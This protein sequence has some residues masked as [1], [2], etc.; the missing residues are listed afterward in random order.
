MIICEKEQCTGCFACVNICPQKCITMTEM[1]FGCIHPKVDDDA[2]INCGLCIKVCPNNNKIPKHAARHVYAS[3]SKDDTDRVASTSGGAAT[4]FS[5]KMIQDGGVVFGAAIDEHCNIVHK[6][7]DTIESCEGFRGSKYVQSH[8]EYSYTNAKKKL[9]EDIPVLFIGTPCQIAGLL[10]YLQKP[11][12]NLITCDLICH[13]TPPQKLLREHMK[14]VLKKEN[15]GG[16]RFTFRSTLGFGMS[17]K[18]YEKNKKI[19]DKPF[20]NDLYYLGF[21]KALFCRDSCYQC[22]YASKERISDITIGDFWGLGKEEAFDYDVKRGVSLIIPN[23]DKGQAFVNSCEDKLELFER[24]I[25]EAAKGNSQLNHPSKAHIKRNEFIKSY[26][27]LGFNK[28][29]SKALLKD[30]FKY[31]ILYMIFKFPFLKKIILKIR[32]K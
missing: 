11:Y 32:R 28:A 19:Y 2:C 12:D 30:R 4:V 26:N 21:E 16:L 8:I 31:P 24:T 20:Y 6:A 1:E 18:V 14:H 5:K 13:G 15:L 10:S 17:F 7:A 9:K 22:K 3:W 25:D 27:K 29:A 23:T